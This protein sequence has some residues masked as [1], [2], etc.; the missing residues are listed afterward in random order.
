MNITPVNNNQSFGMAFR[1]K[2]DA[3]RK[4]SEKFHTSNDAT[5]AKNY[6]MDNIAN[7]IKALKSEVI[8]DGQKVFVK[9]PDK[10]K[11]IE[12]LDNG[13]NYYYPWVSDNYHSINFHVADGDKRVYSVHYDSP[14]NAKGGI[15]HEFGNLF[16]SDLKLHCAR[17]IAKDMDIQA[18][19]AAARQYELT[20]KKDAIDKT[21]SELQDIFG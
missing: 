16:D 2:G 10:D 11:A 19:K 14:Q 17:E 9:S 18:S 6:F 5:A 15:W 13:R 4:L 20:L 8:Y 21:A 7:P 1:L 12:V 3:A